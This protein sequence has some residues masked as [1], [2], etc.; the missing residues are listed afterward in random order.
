MNVIPYSDIFLVQI[1][2]SGKAQRGILISFHRKVYYNSH[3]SAFTARFDIVVTMVA[4]AK[5]SIESGLLPL[6]APHAKTAQCRIADGMNP[7]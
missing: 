3:T 4:V 1:S 7:Q 2:L 5:I 6:K